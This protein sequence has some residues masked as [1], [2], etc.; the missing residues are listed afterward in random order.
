MMWWQLYFGHIG[1]WMTFI[2]VNWLIKTKGGSLK[3]FDVA[4]MSAIFGLF[5]A[6]AHYCLFLN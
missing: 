1:V 2:T 3:I 5:S 6:T 4:V